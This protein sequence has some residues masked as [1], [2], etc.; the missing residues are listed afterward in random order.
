MTTLA[1]AWML[2][3]YLRLI[4]SGRSCL[5]ASVAFLKMGIEEQ[6]QKAAAEA[7][8]DESQAG[9]VYALCAIAEAV[10]ATHDSVVRLSDE[11]DALRREIAL[12]ST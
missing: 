7:G 3:G 12:I 6:R 11:V 10:L 2:F 5:G 1:N 8:P 9:Q 4:P